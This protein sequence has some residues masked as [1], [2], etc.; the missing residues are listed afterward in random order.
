MPDCGLSKLPNPRPQLAEKQAPN[1]YND[2]I[3][4]Q[5]DA[6]AKKKEASWP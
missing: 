2:L 3:F 4:K 1:D 5:A 6:R